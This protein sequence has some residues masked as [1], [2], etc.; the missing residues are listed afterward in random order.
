MTATDIAPTSP[1]AAEPP[2]PGGAAT[3]TPT[4]VDLDELVQRTGRKI[5]ARTERASR[6][7]LTPA[8]LL[9]K[10]Q[11]G[12][13]QVM[14]KD[15]DLRYRMLR[16]TDVYPALHN[17]RMIADHL[18][19]YLHSSAL[20][21]GVKSTPLLGT[22]RRLAKIG[23]V[24]PPVTGAISRF[25]IKQMATQFIAGDTPE[26]VATRI[27]AMEGDGFLFSLDL[28]G[29][30]VAS[31]TQADE[32]AGRYR[33]MA[34]RFD[35]LLGHRAEGPFNRA[36]LNAGPRVNISIK[37]S[38]LTSKFEPADPEG[39]SEAVRTRLR[40]L[41]RAAR[42]SGAFLNIDM[43]KFEY[44]NLSLRIIRDLLSEE[45][46]RGIDFIGTVVQ[47]YLKDADV[48]LKAFLDW[49]EANSQPMT[50]RLVKGAY[51]DSEQIWARAKGWPN[52]V[53]TVKRETDAMYERCLKMLLERHHA[54]RTAVASH[55]VR[56]I[57]YALTLKKVLGVPD[58][59]FE[60]QMLFG[61]AGPIKDALR[62]MG[63]PVRI[64][65]P[66]GELLPG[67]AYLV[68][69][70]LENTSN[71]SFL[72]QRFSDG[73]SPTALL[74]DPKKAAPLFAEANPWN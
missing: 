14:M 52:P 28:L 15:E 68:R 58:D 17:N 47:A 23:R 3:H 34:E 62:A 4:T 8:A 73:V 71:E 53:I 38:S 26:S 45:E 40:P 72:R 29:E 30:F 31:E 56:S 22:V 25:A 49:L 24:V 66:C 18:V 11:D 74:A 2:P 70:I 39:T 55:N 16:F 20:H 54:V 60:C 42:E 36:S 48:S 6:T 10:F 32:F 43:E 12:M 41:F 9:G 65:T 67:M 61:M 50:I 27:R 35:D 64:Y 37:L 33:D 46:F 63:V 51:W 59:R 21:T 19:E 69:R 44:R 5:F 1:Q 13:L 7:R 57:A